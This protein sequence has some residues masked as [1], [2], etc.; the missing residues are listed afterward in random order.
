MKKLL[1]TLLI[2]SILLGSISLF[3]C[4]DTSDK[5]DEK[6]PERE[7]T[8]EEKA[9]FDQ[10]ISIMESDVKTDEFIAKFF[11]DFS[12]DQINTPSLPYSRIYKVGDVIALENKNGETTYQKVLDGKLYQVYRTNDGAKL[13]LENSEEYPYDYPLSVFTVFG[14]DMSQ[15]YSTDAP[16]KEEPK[17]T[18]DN[19]E[20]SKDKKSVIMNEDFLSD[21][22]EFL[23]SSLEPSKE[24]MKAFLKDMTSEGVYTINDETLK[25]LIEGKFKTLGEIK[26]EATYT[27]KDNKPETI[28]MIMTMGVEQEGIPVTVTMG[29]KVSGIKYDDNGE[30][31]SLVF[32]TNSTTE[33]QVSQNGITIDYVTK[34]DGTYRFSLVDL[35]TK[36][37]DIRVTTDT[38]ASY[39]GQ[40]QSSKA[41]L[42]VSTKGDKLYY[43]L[44]SENV[45]N[46][47]VNF[48]FGTPQNVTIPEDIYTVL[49]ETLYGN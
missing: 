14:I 42:W 32:E 18:Y 48:S 41:I 9:L 26:I 29:Q 6:E 38:T 34:S 46:F 10:A 37:I 49:P 17:L 39:L 2:I 45:I 24:E 40:T 1:S 44:S 13:H 31:T 43:N 28:S 8:D 30:I 3:S 11:C 15:I 36:I 20:L 5:V 7:I 21:L 4:N 33:Y 12:I 27:Q 22:A 19:L 16:E 23:C 47:T 25:I 35:A